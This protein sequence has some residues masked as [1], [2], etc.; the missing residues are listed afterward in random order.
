MSHDLLAFLS[1]MFC[2]CFFGIGVTVVFA[3][4]VLRAVVRFAVLSRKSRAQ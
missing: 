1:G 2:G 3:W 4:R